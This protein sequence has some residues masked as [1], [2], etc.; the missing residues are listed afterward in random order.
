MTKKRTVTVII[1]GTEYVVKIGNLNDRPITAV[2][3]KQTYQVQ[4]PEKQEVQN[5][6][7]SIPKPQMVPVAP[8]RKTGQTIAASG[9]VIKAPMPGDILDVF[10]K[11]GDEVEIGQEICTLE[12]MKMKNIIRSPIAGAIGDVLVAG[13]QSVNFDDTLVIFE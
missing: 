13:N 1:D 5:S 8:D 3:N 7:K 11:V 4:V 12:A 9:N 10:V 2:V 6:S